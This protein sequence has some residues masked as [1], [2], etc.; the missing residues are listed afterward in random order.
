MIYRWRFFQY[1]SPAGR[2]SVDDWRKEMPIGLPRADL[3]N[4][5]KLLAKSTEWSHPDIAPLHGRPYRGLT[6]LRWKSGRVP[7]R[8]IGYSRRQPN[9]PLPGEYILL[10]GCTHNA[11]KYD[12]PSALETARRYREEIL[13]GKARTCEYRLITDQPN[14]G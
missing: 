8:L 6:E 7:Y 4:F 1:E 3:D 10:I 2:K 13:Q 14:E 5:L 11:K 12:P 9:P